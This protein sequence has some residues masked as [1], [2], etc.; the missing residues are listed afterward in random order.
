MK[1]LL[2][3]DIVSKKIF[4]LRGHKVMISTNLSELYR[5]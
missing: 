2:V 4:Y 1:D 3:Q 5:V